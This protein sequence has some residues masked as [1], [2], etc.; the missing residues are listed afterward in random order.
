MT[1]NQKNIE[2]LKECTDG[3]TFKSFAHVMITAGMITSAYKELYPNAGNQSFEEMW[4]N[5]VIFRSK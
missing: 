4:L 1:D 5:I 2:I 3:L